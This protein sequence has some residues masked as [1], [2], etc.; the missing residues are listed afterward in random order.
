[1]V[2]KKDLETLRATKRIVIN[3]LQRITA[4]GKC[5]NRAGKKR[6]ERK[7]CHGFISKFAAEAPFVEYIKKILS[8]FPIAD[9]HLFSR[10]PIIL[11]RSF[12]H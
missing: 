9:R 4:H 12:I 2:K 1:M 3:K 11:L 10:F 5:R 6:Q 8:L 7:V